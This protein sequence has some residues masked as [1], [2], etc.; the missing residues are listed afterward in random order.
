MGL[1]KERTTIISGFV[2]TASFKSSPAFEFFLIGNAIACTYSLISMPFVYNLMEGY[3]LQILDKVIMSLVM[4]SAA[5]ATAI[6]Y[7]GLNGDDSIGWSKVCPYYEKFCHRASVSLIMSYLGFLL[8]LIMCVV[9][10]VHN[11]PRKKASS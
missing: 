1:S 11:T 9:S 2:I 6:G 8:F 4:A 5:A 7:L 10:V 3:T